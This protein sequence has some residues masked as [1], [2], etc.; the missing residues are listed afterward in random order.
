[1]QDE[2]QIFSKIDG[3]KDLVVEMQTRMIACPAVSPITA[4]TEKTP[5]HS[6]CWACLKP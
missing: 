1:M 2:K 3:Y 5:K 4:E 6:I